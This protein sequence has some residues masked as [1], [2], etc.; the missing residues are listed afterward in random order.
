MEGELPDERSCLDSVSKLIPGVRPATRQVESKQLSLLHP[1]R[2]QGLA[3]GSASIS[4]IQNLVG[5]FTLTLATYFLVLEALHRD[6]LLVGLAVSW[7]MLGR[8]VK[9]AR[10]VLSEPEALLFLPLVTLVFIVVMIPIKWYALFTLNKQGWITR[11]PDRVVAEGQGG[12]T[13]G[14]ASGL[15]GR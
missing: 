3:L 13:L 7:L 5:P 12:E 6:W 15:V 11:R 10:H 1:G 9:S 2:G 4:V 14:L 8:A